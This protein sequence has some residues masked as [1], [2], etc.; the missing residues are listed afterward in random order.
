MKII[1]S[2]EKKQFEFE[3]HPCRIFINCEIDYIDSPQRKIKPLLINDQF[4]HKMQKQSVVDFLSQLPQNAAQK[5]QII[6]QSPFTDALKMLI[7]D[8]NDQTKIALLSF[9]LKTHSAPIIHFKKPSSYFNITQLIPLPLQLIN[10]PIIL[11]ED[12]IFPVGADFDYV[13]TAK[14]LISLDS[15]QPLLDELEF[16]GTEA[17]QIFHARLFDN[18]DG[19]FLKCGEISFPLDENERANFMGLVGQKFLWAFNADSFEYTSKL[20]PNFLRL[21]LL[22]QANRGAYSL[23]RFMLND[24]ILVARLEKRLPTP[25][26]FIKPKF[27]KCFY[28]HSEHKEPLIL[29]TNP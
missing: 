27:H 23:A 18:G 9:F 17:Y 10:V 21:E 8:L 25:Y 28:Y 26:I 24:T 2:R 5:K 11:W 3:Q 29:K 22:S 6:S 15:Q 4:L 16:F 1:I 19:W 20:K 7:K 14:Q 13:L 12:R